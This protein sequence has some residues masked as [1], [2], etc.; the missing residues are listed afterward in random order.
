MASL[1]EITQSALSGTRKISRHRTRNLAMH[2]DDPTGRRPAVLLLRSRNP[3]SRSA[4]A[5][6]RANIRLDVLTMVGPAAP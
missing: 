2:G 6:D 3:R 5:W 1:I 4:S